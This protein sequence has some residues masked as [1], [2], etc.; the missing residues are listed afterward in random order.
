MRGGS[1]TAGSSS[2]AA[3]LGSAGQ[4]CIDLAEQRVDVLRVLAPVDEGELRVERAVT[5]MW[6]GDTCPTRIPR[7]SP[8]DDHDAGAERLTTPDTRSAWFTVIPA[9]SAAH[10]AASNT[11]S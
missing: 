10:H 6:P 1:M 11:V 4:G 7:F 5:W 2:R 3:S 8:Q 9:S